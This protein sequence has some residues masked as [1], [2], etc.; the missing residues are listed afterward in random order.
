MMTK[1]IDTI[2]TS[3]VDHPEDVKITSKEDDNTITYTLSV[4]KEDMGK[5]IGKQGR[6]AKVILTVSYPAGSTQQKKIY[7]EISE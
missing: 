6:V 5:V 1:L 2:V 7:L 3:L 4:H